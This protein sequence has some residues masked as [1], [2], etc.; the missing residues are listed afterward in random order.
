MSGKFSRIKSNRNKGIL[1]NGYLL[2]YFIVR[3]NKTDSEWVA[4]KGSATGSSFDT[5]KIRS[6]RQ[7]V[8]KAVGAGKP[9]SVDTWNATVKRLINER[10]AM[11]I[12]DVRV[13]EPLVNIV[14][15]D[16][17]T[18]QEARQAEIE[19]SA[20]NRFAGDTNQSWLSHQAGAKAGGTVRTK[21]KDK[22]K[23]ITDIAE[24]LTNPQKKKRRRYS[25]TS[26]RKC[27]D[28]RGYVK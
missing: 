2:P 17:L 13:R 14:Y 11:S 28:N 16:W 8:S 7:A 18:D 4:K 12:A 24:G 3:Y 1:Y 21:L 15:N 9:M 27:G 19:W 23:V 22:A 10:M 6:F 25:R 26:R 20:N 5:N